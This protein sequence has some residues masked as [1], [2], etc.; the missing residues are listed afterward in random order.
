[1]RRSPPLLAI[2]AVAFAIAGAH[3]SNAGW[4]V[5]RIGDAGHGYL[6]DVAVAGNAGGRRVTVWTRYKK[7]YAAVARAGRGFGRR[8][9]VW[10]DPRGVAYPQIAMNRRGD[11]LILWSYFDGTYVAGPYDREGDCCYGYRLAVLRRDGH[12]TRVQ[13]LT[14]PG[15]DVTV[16]GYVIDP[17]GRVGVA[18][19][20][21]PFEFRG[22]EG[23]FARFSGPH[24]LRPTRRIERYGE[25][26]AVSF[27]HGRPRVL[28]VVPARGRNRLVERAGRVTGHFGPRTVVARGLPGYVELNAAVDEQGD[29]A[30]AWWRESYERRPVWAGTRAPGK[31]LRVRRIARTNQDYFPSVAID[32][33][34]AAAVAWPTQ[35]DLMVATAAP[36]ARFNRA[37]PVFGPRRSDLLGSA[38]EVAVNARREVVLAWTS[39][40]RGRDTIHA[41]VQ[42]ASGRLTH[43]ARLARGVERLT[44]A[45]AGGA[46][47]DKRGRATVVWRHNRDVRVASI[48]V[49]R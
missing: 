10:R 2:T 18:W 16:G 15:R 12:L 34:G 43:S 28:S 47:L 48:T 25:P 29:E 26:A 1:M 39:E 35:R 37:K 8:R 4:R 45:G 46:A 49:P 14:P 7:L 27:V 40:R 11:A 31:P 36:G 42:T 30:V 9:L 6:E 32:G 20:E 23:V 24:G 3:A 44:L 33:S 38:V 41:A 19:S 5:E 13:T 17:D 22:R 21:Y